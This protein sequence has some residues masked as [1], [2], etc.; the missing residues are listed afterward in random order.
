MLRFSTRRGATAL[1]PFPQ[2]AA[3]LV[4]IRLTVPDRPGSLGL[5]A[6]AIG[7]AGADVVQLEVLSS[8]NGRAVDDVHVTVHD[9][10]HLDRLV[11]SLGAVAGVGVEG[12]L[13][14]PPPVTGHAELE[15]VARVLAAPARALIT[16]VDGVCAAVG[17][18]WAVVLGATAEGSL[19]TVVLAGV[20]A[21]EP[22]SLPGGLA[23]GLPLRLGTPRLAGPDGTRYG[24]AAVVPLGNAPL[25]LLVVRQAGPAFHRSELWRLAELG[26]IAG[27]LVDSGTLAA[28]AGQA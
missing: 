12:V 18:D 7:C 2:G 9:G 24:G 19:D 23:A 27:H 16:L 6:S 22:D 4:R 11:R 21:P 20:S 10:G 17:A 28:T 14:S 15:L 13:H 8:E 5:V 1:R 26:R 25:A 3:V